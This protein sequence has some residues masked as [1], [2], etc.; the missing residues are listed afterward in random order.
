MKGGGEATGQI[1]HIRDLDSSA[2]EER[3]VSASWPADRL[4]DLAKVCLLLCRAK[5]V[6]RGPSKSLLA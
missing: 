2:I 6:G 5:D 3:A 4:H 1:K